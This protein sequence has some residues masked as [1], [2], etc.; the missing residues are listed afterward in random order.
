MSS[1][2]FV[3]HAQASLFES[4]YDQLSELGRRQA[5]QLGQYVAR[6]GLEYDEIY[7][8]PCRRH[9]QSAEIVVQNGGGLS[10]EI[11]EIAELDEHQV[12]RLVTHH[13]EKIADRFPDVVKLDE[14]FRSKEILGERQKSFARLFQAVADLWVENRCPLFGVESRPEFNKR[15]NK[16]I[17]QIVAQ[18]G[19]GRRILVFTSA[20]TIAVALQ[21]ALS[22]PDEVALGLSWKIWNCSLTEFVFS[23]DRFSLDR[24]NALP[25]IDDRNDR[26]Y[27]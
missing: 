3:R 11:V 23:G 13:I 26:T 14:E 8:G 22:C 2:V 15:V 21:R 18:G 9:W 17:D 27:R 6:H 10:P 25:H 7:T 20:G 16:G 1:I 12:D 19:R 24:F 5:C 4:D